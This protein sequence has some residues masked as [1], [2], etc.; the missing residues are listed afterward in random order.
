MTYI[1]QHANNLNPILVSDN[2]IDNSTS[3]FLVGKNVPDY[4]SLLDQNFLQLM[5]NFANNVAPINP[6]P[7]Q[8]WYDVGGNGAP[9]ILKVFNGVRFKSVV[10]VISAT[11]S[12]A[13]PAIGDLWLDTSDSAHP[14]LMMYT[15]SG[16]VLVGPPRGSGEVISEQIQ[17]TSGVFHDV[18]SMKINGVRYAIMVKDQQFTPYPVGTIPGFAKLYPGLNLANTSFIQNN[19]F[20]GRSTDSDQLEGLHAR[21]FMRSDADTGTTGTLS[22][23][24][25]N[26]ILLGN[27]HY[28]MSI[29]GADTLLTSQYVNGAI[30]NLVKRPGT[31]G[32][33]GAYDALDIYGNGEVGINSSLTVNNMGNFKGGLQ[34]GGGSADH[35]TQWA[36]DGTTI[37]YTPN[38]VNNN[39]YLQVDQQLLVTNGMGTAGPYTPEGQIQVLTNEPASIVV[40]NTNR[41][42]DQYARLV[43]GGAGAAA[44]ASTI[45]YHDYTDTLTDQAIFGW[46]SLAADGTLR[47][48][49]ANYQYISNVWSF[50]G[51][52]A[53]RAQIDTALR[54]V[55]GTD[56]RSGGNISAAGYI[57]SS[58]TNL[59]ITGGRANQHLVTTGNGNL[60]WVD[61]VA[62]TDVDSARRLFTPRDIKLSGDATGNLG[63]NLFDGQADVTI[64]TSVNRLHVPRKIEATGDATWYVNFDG[65][66][67]VSSGL[68]L[69]DL[70][71]AGTY[72]SVNVNNKGLVTGGSTTNPLTGTQNAVAYFDTTQSIGSTGMLWDSTNS[73]M[74]LT[75][76]LNVT[77][78]IVAFSTSDTRLKT[79]LEQITNPLSKLSQLTGYTFNWNEIAKTHYTNK[80]DKTEVGLIAQEVADVMP[81]VV[82]V[83]EDG[84]MAVDYAKLVPLL[85]EAIKELTEE[86]EKLKGQATF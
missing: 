63:S 49:L 10:T 11:A 82:T 18:I 6:I 81:E 61:Q 47:Q 67:N 59:K 32:D 4:G 9:P 14:G 38:I 58:V 13:G 53:L 85:V 39:G 43:L 62:Y 36:T 24:N 17:D 60:Q 40:K 7:G 72:Y 12:P 70:G 30:R 69:A 28:T 27:S 26:G 79:N 68:T 34:A 50:F 86:V 83:R 56:I 41:G 25:D 16:W 42:P 76:T 19:R 44:D 77:Q 29:R 21:Q 22:V 55:A 75:G 73:L 37:T 51:G 54:T 71:A 65:S 8:L 15:A 1:I 3:V 23:Y 46:S 2:T 80:T 57:N 64:N 48:P 20:V 35:L 5:E 66:Q 78:D 31:F 84:F 74:T 45:Q 33:V 52:G